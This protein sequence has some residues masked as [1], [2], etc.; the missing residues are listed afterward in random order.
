MRWVVN[1]STSKR[2][3]STLDGPRSIQKY[4]EGPDEPGSTWSEPEVPNSA[5][6]THKFKYTNR[7]G[8]TLFDMDETEPSIR[9][10]FKE[11]LFKTADAKSANI[12][13]YTYEFQHLKTM[14]NYE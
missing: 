6:C 2:T 9:K 13:S 12:W 3:L 8:R 4:P 14:T 1:P 11:S 10:K 7:P 5:G